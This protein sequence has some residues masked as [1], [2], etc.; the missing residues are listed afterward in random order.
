M[1]KKSIALILA[2]F[3]GSLLLTACER[4]APIPPTVATATVGIPFPLPNQSTLPAGQIGTQTAVAQTTPG[5]KAVTPTAQGGKPPA[6]TQ[7][8]VQPTKAQPQPTKPPA[9][10]PT[11]RPVVVVA[12]P[13]RPSTYTVQFGDTFYCIARRYNL[14]VGDFL[15]LNGLSNNSFAQSG[16]VVKIPSSGTWGDG[17]RSLHSHPDTYTVE[18]G[19]SLNK[20]ACYYGDVYPEVIL[21]VN[22]LSSASDIKPGMQLNIP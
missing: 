10:Q 20:I 14:N 19:D 8:V 3:V 7:Q 17:S 6:A 5:V 4:P 18:T 22:D 16:Q 15:S 11:S 13:S 1:N 9:V 21:D 12:T 2:V